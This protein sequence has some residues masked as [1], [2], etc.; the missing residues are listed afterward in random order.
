MTLPIRP[1][2]TVPLPGPLHSHRDKLSELADLGY[3]DIYQ[4]DSLGC[5]AA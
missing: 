4:A 1:G 3:T 2:M 5:F